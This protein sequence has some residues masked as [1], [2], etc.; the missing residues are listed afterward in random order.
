MYNRIIIVV[1]EG[2]EPVAG[3]GPFLLCPMLQRHIGQQ[4]R[5]GGVWA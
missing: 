1:S 5:P 3:G 2:A 4:E